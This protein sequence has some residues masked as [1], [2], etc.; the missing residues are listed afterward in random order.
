MVLR[1]EKGAASVLVIVLM[2]VLIILGLAIAS[3]S[4][5]NMNL[6]KKKSDWVLNYYELSGEAEKKLADIIDVINLAKERSADDEEFKEM[7]NREFAGKDFR[8][9]I[10]YGQVGG[11]CSL[12]FDIKEEDSLYNKRLEVSLAIPLDRNAKE[13]YQITKYALLQEPLLQ[14]EKEEFV[15]PFENMEDN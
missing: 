6:S 13:P 3:T 9:A 12:Y 1:D 14:E 11:D 7:L 2:L 10:P 15:D 8:F 5:S 4:I